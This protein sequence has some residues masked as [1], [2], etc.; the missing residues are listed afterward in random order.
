M[1]IKGAPTPIARRPAISE[2]VSITASEET[3]PEIDISNLSMVAVRK[4]SGSGTTAAVWGLLEGDDT[5]TAMKDSNGDA[6]TVALGDLTVVNP[7]VFAASSI[8]LVGDN[9][10]VVR[11]GGKT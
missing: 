8:K 11:V 5:Y 7:S 3:S 2:S 10:A 4:V 1:E 6:I 9:T